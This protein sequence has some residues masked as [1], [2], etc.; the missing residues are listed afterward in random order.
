[1]NPRHRLLAI[2]LACVLA[3]LASTQLWPMTLFAM[4]PE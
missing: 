2:V 4:L 1:M 3:V